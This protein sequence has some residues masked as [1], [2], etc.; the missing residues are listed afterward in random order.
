[1]KNYRPILE[2]SLLSAIAC[3]LTI[4]TLAYSWSSDGFDQAEVIW[5]AVLPGLITFTISLTLISICLSKY[6]KDCRTRDIVPAKWWQLL[7][8]TSFLVTVFMIAIDAAF[9]YVADNTLSSS[10]AEALGTFDQSSSAMK[11]STIKA[12][13]A[14]PFLMQ[15]GVT[16]AL[17][18]L[19]ANSLAVAVAKYTTKK[20]VL[21]LQ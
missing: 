15:N 8:G 16:I 19:I 20:P 17:F 5:L 4:Y 7:L 18:I 10:Y 6:L 1:M 9:F 21:E 3:L 2:F 12:F 11:E 13:A 14:L